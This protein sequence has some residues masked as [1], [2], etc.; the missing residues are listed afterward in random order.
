VQGTAAVTFIGC[1]PQMVHEQRKSGQ[2]EI[3]G[4]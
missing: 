2:R 3:V 1:E 4:Q